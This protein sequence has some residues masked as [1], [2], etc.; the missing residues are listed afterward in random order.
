MRLTEEQM[1]K[2]EIQDAVDEA[3]R[4]RDMEIE[5]SEVKK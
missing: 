1:K 3:L 5:Y 2:I 4:I